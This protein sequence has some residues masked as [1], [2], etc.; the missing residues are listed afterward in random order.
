MLKTPYKNHKCISLQ[1]VFP[2][3][4]GKKL[5]YSSANVLIT[6]F[7]HTDYFVEKMFIQSWL[8]NLL[9]FCARK[10]FAPIFANRS[11]TTENMCLWSTGLNL[12]LRLL[13]SSLGAM[14]RSNQ[15]KQ[16]RKNHQLWTINKI[17]PPSVFLE[18]KQSSLSR[19]NTSQ[20]LYNF[21]IIQDFNELHL[22]VNFG[23]FES[24]NYSN[25]FLLL[26]IDKYI[27]IWV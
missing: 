10:K 6:T 9:N 27:V 20:S 4:A 14:M 26:K 18:P 24:S 7:R 11:S 17:R 5:I 19:W 15:V 2:K 25:I 16:L 12:L 22:M 13:S 21:A 8:M 1:K 3:F 23:I